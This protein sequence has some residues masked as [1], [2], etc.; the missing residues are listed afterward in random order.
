MKEK[1]FL[2]N[3]K[4]K[5]AE[6]VLLGVPDSSGSHSK[7]AKG[8][9]KAPNYIRKVSVEE[10]TFETDKG[11]S[12]AYASSGIVDMKVHDL[13]NIKKKAIRKEISRI[14]KSDKM[15]VVL[16]GDHSITTEIL[17][18][19]N[20]V[21]KDI[22]LI[23][24]DAHPDFICTSKD[25][26]YG[27][28]VCDISKLRNFNIK[29]SLEIGIRVPEEEESKELKKRN[30]MIITPFDIKELGIKKTFEKIKKRVGKSKNI[31][32]SIDMDVIDPA[33]APGVDTPVPGG[34]SSTEFIY[35]AKKIAGLGLIGMD[36]TEVNPKE[37]VKGRTGHLASRIIAEVLGSLQ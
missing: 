17:K 35:L 28:V 32:L 20:G 10:D 31:Y 5:D 23:Y 25:E 14:I 30:L 24:F 19:V 27:S 29:K 7:R 4:L 12:K 15:P 2:H 22:S 1:F 33:F 9:A 11:R 26:Y 13:G 34:L 36:I 3:S 8:V 37:D 6:V 18:G 16:G 21:K